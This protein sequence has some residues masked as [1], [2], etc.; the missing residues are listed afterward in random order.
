M[1][2]V[3]K[4]S[5]FGMDAAKRSLEAARNAKTPEEKI[6]RLTDAVEALYRHL[7]HLE[8]EAKFRER[9]GAFDDF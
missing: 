7:K 1:S 8:A 5:G 6:E 3:G 2:D 9:K 4:A